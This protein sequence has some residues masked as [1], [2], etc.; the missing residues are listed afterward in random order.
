MHEKRWL[1]FTW[2]GVGLGEDGTLWGGDALLGQPGDWQRVACLRP[3]RLPGGDKVAREPW[4]SAL[5]ACWQSNTTWSEAP[6]GTDLLKSAWEQGVNTVTTTAAGRLFD[7]AAA[8][9]GL[10]TQASF[11]GQGPMQLEAACDGSG[12]A[13]T[14][15][16]QRNDD[17]AWQCDWAPLMQMLM[18]T[19]VAV[20]Q[21]AQ[22]FHSSLA[23][24]I[25]EQAI[26]MRNEQG[27][28]AVGLSG[29]V[30]QNRVLTEAAMAFLRDAGFR[31]Y[32]PQQVPCND[33]GL[34]YGQ[35]IEAVGR[36]LTNK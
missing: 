3:F 10:C 25:C 9:T 32:L 35:I 34:C 16:L 22:Q 23:K 8:L 7:A 5:A 19:E 17:D 21:R 26:A 31:V 11:E 30:F 28:F 24:A 2:D 15:P 36:H 29:G 4:R 14:L 27:D 12:D 33:G 1:V 13:I 18:D 20:G 6:E